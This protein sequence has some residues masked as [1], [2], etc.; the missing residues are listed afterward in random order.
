MGYQDLGKYLHQVGD[1]GGARKAFNKMQD[2]LTTNTQ[3]VLLIMRCLNLGIDEQN[4]Y[5]VGVSISRIWSNGS[6]KYDEAKRF[7]RNIHCAQGLVHLASHHFKNAAESFLAVEPWPSLNASD[8]DQN[9]EMLREIIAP[10][11]IAVY[12]GLCALASYSRQELLSLVLNGK[13]FRTFLELEPH[14]R[15]ALSCFATSNFPGAFSI[16]HAWRADFCIDLHL[17]PCIDVLFEK[18][19]QRAMAQYASPYS[20]VNLSEMADAFAQEPQRLGPKVEELISTGV[21]NGKIDRVQNRF[22][23]SGAKTSTTNETSI[24][25][26]L[27]EYERIA[28]L[29]LLRIEAQFARL[30]LKQ[31]KDSATPAATSLE[32]RQGLALQSISQA[33]K[34]PE[35]G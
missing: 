28:Y 33:P 6:V 32:A 27:A 20:V 21:L 24:L 25:G 23:A 16:L 35:A 4:W 9:I 17:S 8:H 7:V 19:Q 5:S 22:I 30:E 31:S 29:Q 34:E 10:A 14:I 1:L 2:Y 26:I 11:D 15:H 13:Y 18:I 3:M 12:G